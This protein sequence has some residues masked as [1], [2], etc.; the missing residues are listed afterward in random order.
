M[1]TFEG[2]DSGGDLIMRDTRCT[3]EG[4]PRRRAAEAEGFDPEDRP[5]RDIIPRI[6]AE[7]TDGGI[8]TDYTTGAKDNAMRD[9]TSIIA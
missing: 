4:T 9:E 2:L 5:D 7:R 3:G 8:D 1:S 6:P